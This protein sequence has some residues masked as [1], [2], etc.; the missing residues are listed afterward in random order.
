MQFG[1]TLLCSNQRMPAPTLNCCHR[2]VPSNHSFA[3]L[4]SCYFVAGNT[5]AV[6]NQNPT[7]VALMLQ[8]VHI[9]VLCSAATD[10]S[11]CGGSVSA[12]EGSGQDKQGGRY[13]P[14][15]R[16]CSACLLTC[17]KVGQFQLHK[18]SMPAH[19]KHTAYVQL[20]LT[21]SVGQIWCLSLLQQH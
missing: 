12:G 2:E 18:V 20:L 14:V 8:A 9:R 15:F 10:R 1:I 6:Q 17:N 5:C 16:W 3:V 7:C 13:W 21:K 4:W 19:N 11:R